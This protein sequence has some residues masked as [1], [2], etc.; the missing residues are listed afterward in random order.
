MSDSSNQ[1]AGPAKPSSVPALHMLK[2]KY[3]AFMTTFQLMYLVVEFDGMAEKAR[4]VVKW[5]VWAYNSRGESLSTSVMTLS[6]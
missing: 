4:V 5:G 2:S 1:E 3:C 6:I